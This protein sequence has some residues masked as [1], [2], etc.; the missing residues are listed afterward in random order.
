MG[1]GYSKEQAGTY[2]TLI[3]VSEGVLQYALGGIS[4]LGG[5]LTG[6]LAKTAIQNIDKVVLRIAA[7]MPIRMGGEFAEEYLQAVLEPAF[8][9]MAFN[10]HNEIRLFSPDNFYQGMIGAF[11]AGL[12]EGGPAVARNISNTQIGMA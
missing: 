6:N 8:R 1:Q 7:E 4:K 11:T 9:N 12:L 10:E 2:S 3:G 5:K